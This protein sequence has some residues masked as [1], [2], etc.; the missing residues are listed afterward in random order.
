M[1]N[2]LKKIMASVMAITSLSI[3]MTGMNTSAADDIKI[4]DRYSGPD[5]VRSFDAN[6]SYH[7]TATGNA[8]STW[9]FFSTSDPYAYHVSINIINV[10]GTVYDPYYWYSDG[11]YISHSYSCSN[12]T[13]IT[14]RHVATE[15]GGEGYTDIT[16][17]V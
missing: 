12:L 13:S 10:N 17:Y 5:T 15:S 4:I 9:A 14:C 11:T 8:G 16:R 1:K 2:T 7:A 3:G 6:I